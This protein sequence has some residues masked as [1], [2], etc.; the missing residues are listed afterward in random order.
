MM[1]VQLMTIEVYRDLYLGNGF[2]QTPEEDS[3][4]KVGHLS[5][6]VIPES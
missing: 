1:I 3:Q 5:L 6:Q 2:G 4:E